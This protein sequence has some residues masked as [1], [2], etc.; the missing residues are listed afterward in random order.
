LLKKDFNFL[1]LLKES[2]KNLYIMNLKKLKPVTSG[3]RHQLNIQKFLLSKNNR[4]VRSN[5][6]N[7]K[8]CY[9]RSPQTGHITAW[10]RGGGHKRLFRNIDFL[11][12]N[13]CSINLVSFYDPNRTSFIFLNFDLKKKV[14]FQTL[15]TNSIYPG[16]FSLCKSDFLELKLGYR[17]QI[18]NVPTGSLIHT[19][20]LSERTRGQYIRSAGTFGQI[21]QKDE[22]KAKVRLPSNNI[23]DVSVESYVTLGVLSNLQHNLTYLGKAGRNR[24]MGRRPIV[25]G[26]AMN[27]VDHPHGGRTNGGRPSVTPWGLPTKGGFY[28]KKRK[29]N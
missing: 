2:V 4:I 8:L 19:L 23:I 15:A 14:F 3:T 20:S 12:K 13:F 27:P 11:N 18:K 17:T 24:L 10:H 21:I 7:R 1:I 22:K 9:G 16:S 28:L 6:K 25:R 5:F 26:I 29:K